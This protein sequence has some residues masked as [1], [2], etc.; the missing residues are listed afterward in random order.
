MRMESVVTA[1]A[2]LMVIF[3]WLFGFGCCSFAI[4]LMQHYLM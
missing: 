4:S 3:I 1:S 2:I